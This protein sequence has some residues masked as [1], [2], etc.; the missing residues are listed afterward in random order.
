VDERLDQLERQRPRTEDPHLPVGPE[1][2]V[3][4]ARFDGTEHPPVGAGD[5]DLDV[6]GLPLVGHGLDPTAREADRQTV[7]PDPCVHRFA[8]LGILR[9]RAPDALEGFVVTARQ[10]DAHR[11]LSVHCLARVV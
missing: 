9:L 3:N 11:C 6:M 8:L 7:V 10:V 2:V 4:G 5:V 1:R